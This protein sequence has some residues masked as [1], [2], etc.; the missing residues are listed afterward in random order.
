MELLGPQL[1]M[2]IL[3]LFLIW[4]KTSYFTGDLKQEGTFKKKRPSTGKFP[5]NGIEAGQ[6][7]VVWPPLLLDLVMLLMVFNISHFS[8]SF[9]LVRHQDL[10]EESLSS[11]MLYLPESRRKVIRHAIKVLLS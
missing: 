7:S 1:T 8:R 5:L 11:L 9:N 3:T 10:W 2:V 4:A 6:I